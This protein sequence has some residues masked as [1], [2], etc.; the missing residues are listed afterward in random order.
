M[1]LLMVLMFTRALAMCIISYASNI[2]QNQRYK[3]HVLYVMYCINMLYIVSVC[4][5]MLYMYTVCI[6]IVCYVCMD[7]YV[8]YV[9]YDIC[10][11]IK[12]ASIFDV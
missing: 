5:S 8:L 4:Y 11:M 6:C 12:K 10:D 2:M 9:M 1:G 7:V 3:E